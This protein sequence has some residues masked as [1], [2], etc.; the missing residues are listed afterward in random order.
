[1]NL[2]VVKDYYG[3]VLKSSQDLKS[4]ACCDGGGMPA[5]LEALLANV[6]E[7][8]RNKYYG[9]GIVVPQDLRAPACW[10][11]ARARGATFISSRS[12]WGPRARWS[13]SI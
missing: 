10:I 13:A 11:S 5:H 12:L 2:E 9:C 6:H 8:V 1:M 3:K 4:S 7:E